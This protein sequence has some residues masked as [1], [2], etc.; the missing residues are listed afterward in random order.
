LS[1]S[2]RG[3]PVTEEVVK[4]CREISSYLAAGFRPKDI[5]QKMGLSKRAWSWRLRHIRRNAND[6]TDIWA[7]HSA[8]T[9]S[10]YRQLEQIRQKAMDQPK[11][12]LDVARRAISDMMRLD[13]DLIEVGQE[14]G[15]YK[16]MPKKVELEVINPSLSMLYDHIDVEGIEEA[17]LDRLPAPTEEDKVLH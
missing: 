7:L 4:D 8:K 12:S 16:K 17:E 9:D 11:P 10:R 6:A 13:K 2:K 15:V 14:L 3:R 5:R 1:E